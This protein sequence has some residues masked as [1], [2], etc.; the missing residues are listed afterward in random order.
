MVN[1]CRGMDDRSVAACV[2]AYLHLDNPTQNCLAPSPGS[3]VIVD[4]NLIIGMG[5]SPS[6]QAFKVNPTHFSPYQGEF[7]PGGQLDFHSRQHMSGQLSTP[8]GQGSV[9]KHTAAATM[10]NNFYG[11]E[12]SSPFMNVYASGDQF[13][14]RQSINYQPDKIERPSTIDNS[15]FQDAIEPPGIEY[16]STYLSI[17]GGELEDHLLS[18]NIGSGSVEGSSLPQKTGS[19][20][21]GF[22]P[23]VK[24]HSSDDGSTTAAEAG[25][26]S[27]RFHERLHN[28]KSENVSGGTFK[29]IP[30]PSTRGD[31]RRAGAPKRR[32]FAVKNTD[33]FCPTNEKLIWYF[34]Y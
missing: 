13:L 7:T 6:R 16:Q 27:E 24:R 2:P 26:P 22:L 34:I 28:A 4:R 29:D 23:L 11:I 1:F 21:D 14:E 3:D 25:S 10:A 30:F 32:K 9:S 17:E 31:R 20:E 33:L 5:S 18:E 15:Q 8:S 19:E 12:R